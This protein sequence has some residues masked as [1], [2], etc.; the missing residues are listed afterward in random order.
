MHPRSNGWKLLP[1]AAAGS[2][3]TQSDQLY[4]SQPLQAQSQV[5]PQ[6]SQSQATGSSLTN[7]RPI[8]N[9]NNTLSHILESLNQLT[10]QQ[11]YFNESFAKSDRRLEEL[12]ISVS[13]IRETAN[14]LTKKLDVH[15]G[16][17]ETLKRSTCGEDK[18]VKE[19]DAMKVLVGEMKTF[20][21]TL[22][23]SCDGDDGRTVLGRLDAITFAVGDLL[24]R[25]RD[26]EANRQFY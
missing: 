14:G 19:I 20:K 22:G 13:S 7:I 15:D 1:M 23:K 26:P 24:E 11:R 25:A 16:I 5:L 10:V 2:H 3:S 18:K 21:K 6:R 17:L 8:D 9:L 12:I 4:S